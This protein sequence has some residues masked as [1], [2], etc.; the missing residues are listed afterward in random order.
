MLVHTLPILYMKRFCCQLK[1][2]AT[3]SLHAE[4]LSPS[5]NNNTQESILFCYLYKLL[6]SEVWYTQNY[7][8]NTQYIATSILSTLNFILV[9]RDLVVPSYSS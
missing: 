4:T 3:L 9:M 1:Y 8:N 6:K 7:C 5:S 2:L